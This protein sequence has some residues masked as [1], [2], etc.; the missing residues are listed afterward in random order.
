MD[1]IVYTASQV[2]SLLHWWCLKSW[3][4]ILTSVFLL[5]SCMILSKMKKTCWWLGVGAGTRAPVTGKRSSVFYSV[6]MGIFCLQEKPSGENHHYLVN[7]LDPKSR[8]RLLMFFCPS[9]RLMSL[10]S[11]LLCLSGFY[12]C[13]S[14]WASSCIFLALFNLPWRKP[15]CLQM[16]SP[17][18]PRFCLG[19]VNGFGYE[20]KFLWRAE[21]SCLF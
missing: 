14:R 21:R 15:C 5:R 1:L 18:L 20:W 11:V 10:A 17:S 12:D 13:S 16:V 4:Q 9:W 7:Y 19:W 8:E 3:V 2:S 6:K